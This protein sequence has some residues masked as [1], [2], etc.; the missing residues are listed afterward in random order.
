MISSTCTERSSLCS[1]ESGFKV[2]CRSSVTKLIKIAVN[3]YKNHA[4]NNQDTYLKEL[5]QSTERTRRDH[6]E[7]KLMIMMMMTVD[8][9]RN[10][11]GDSKRKRRLKI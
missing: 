1:F 7:R 5:N 4:N 6:K 10:H 11:D 8:D 2:E 9:L 3:L